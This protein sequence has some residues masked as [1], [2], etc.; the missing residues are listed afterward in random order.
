MTRAIVIKTYGDPA[1]SGPMADTVARVVE[2]DAD[3]MGVPERD[4][5]GDDSEFNPTFPMSDLEVTLPDDVY[6]KL[7]DKLKDKGASE[8]GIRVKRE[9]PLPP[10]ESDE[11]SDGNGS[12]DSANGETAADKETSPDGSGDGDEMSGQEM[13]GQESMDELM[14][15]AVSGSEEDAGSDE[16]GAE[17]GESR[18]GSGSKEDESRE[19]ESSSTSS[20]GA[21]EEMEAI[22]PE[23]AESSYGSAASDGNDTEQ[24]QAEANA[25]PSSK[26]SGSQKGQ[27]KDK[28]DPFDGT[29]SMEDALAEIEISICILFRSL[30]CTLVI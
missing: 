20:A 6:D 28:T 27:Q 29:S 15:N 8:D 19:Q 30:Q 17:S 23:D 16:E 3:S 12:Q 2:M 24:E 26:E 13:S 21:G 9:H 14:D 22:D 11:G 7:M 1:W 10:E 4:A 25:K 18:G 5:L